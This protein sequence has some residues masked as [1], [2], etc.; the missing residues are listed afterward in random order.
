MRVFKT[1]WIKFNTQMYDMLKQTCIIVIQR[2]IIKIFSMINEKNTFPDFLLQDI[3]AIELVETLDSTLLHLIVL[4]KYEPI[5]LE[6]ILKL[7]E[8][9]YQLREFIKTHL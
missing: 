2:G 5:L 3:P 7:Y 1:W 8:T 6:T 4:L 9:L